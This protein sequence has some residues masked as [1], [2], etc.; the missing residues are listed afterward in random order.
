MPIAVFKRLAA[1]RP[2]RLAWNTAHAGGWNAIRALLQ[3][4]SLILMARAFGAE[5][6]GALAGSV[7]LYI[8]FAQFAGLGT[9]V[10]LVRHL[11]REGDL[12][13]KLLATQRAYLFTSI[14]L[15]LIVW[16]A[17][18]WLLGNT[19]AASVLAC[20]AAAEMIVAPTLLPLAYRYQAEE[21]MS[22]AGSILTIA[23]LARIISLV[24]I[25]TS[26]QHSIAAFAMIYLGCLIIAVAMTVWRLWPRQHDSIR[27]HHPL[28]ATIRAGLPYVISSVTGTANA[29]LDKTIMLR[30][31]GSVVSGHYAAASRVMQA[32]LFPVNSLVLGTAPRWFSRSRTEG[33]LAGSGWL[34]GATLLYSLPAAIAIWILAP[35]LPLILGGDFEDSVGLLRLLSPVIVTN[36]LRQV[37]AML[38]TTGDLQTARVQI[39]SGAVIAALVAMLVLVPAF[40]AVGA[41]IALIGSDIVVVTLGLRALMHHNKRHTQLHRDGNSGAE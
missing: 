2:G 22:L 40:S 14:A 30:V 21:R 27:H 6:Y 16:P 19:L 5:G 9:G 34:F 41:V 36:A 18:V 26:G 1:W 39:E 20:L 37:V 17:S 24:A 29:E 25:V 13:G 28:M 32:A 7:A 10:A 12:H 15:F 33:P 35:L 8:T 4:G 3:A 31:A 38:L 11:S 23:P